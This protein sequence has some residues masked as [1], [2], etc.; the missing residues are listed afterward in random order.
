MG[1]TTWPMG[2]FCFSLLM[3]LETPGKLTKTWGALMVIGW[4]EKLRVAW[5]AGA[6]GGGGGVV[7]TGLS[8]QRKYSAVVI[9]RWHQMAAKFRVQTAWRAC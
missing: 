3:A 5:G 2:A 4:Q 1:D 9:Y 8:Q 7:Q 6:G